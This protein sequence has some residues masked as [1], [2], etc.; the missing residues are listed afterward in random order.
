MQGRSGSAYL[1]V[2]PKCALIVW[3][4]KQNKTIQLIAGLT[5]KEVQRLEGQL[6]DTNRQRLSILL[7]KMKKAL[8]KNAPLPDEELY[9]AVF[10]EPY[11]KENNFKLRN[12]L[13]LLNICIT[14]FLV[15]ERLK[16]V[17]KDKST[18]YTWEYLQELNDRGLTDLFE[19]ESN[20]T[21]QQYTQTQDLA[22]L[23]KVLTQRLNHEL[24]NT[25]VTEEHY[26][27]HLT[28]IAQLRHVLE[29]QQLI[30]N[31]RL[32]YQWSFCRRVLYGLGQKEH[33]LPAPFPISN[34]EEPLP[35]LALFY[36][37]RANTYLCMG[38]EKIDLLLR[39]LNLC[40]TISYPDFNANQERFTLLAT[41]ALEYY[42]VRNFEQA[43]LYNQ[44]AYSQLHNVDAVQAAKFLHN[45]CSL[46]MR[47]ELFA[48]SLEIIQQH[49]PLI[50][51]T[52]VEPRMRILHAVSL[53][54]TGQPE[55]ALGI[56]PETIGSY[57]QFDRNYI[58]LLEA[59][60]LFDMDN[61]ETALY[62]VNA[63][64]KNL[65]TNKHFDGAPKEF[66]LLFKR[67]IMLEQGLKDDGYAPKIAILYQQ[68][69]EFMQKDNVLFGGDNF[70]VMWLMRKIGPTT[71]KV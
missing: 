45:Y 52:V 41:I 64:I 30:K 2:L 28:Q 67:Y 12:E 1:F 15:E 49:W 71:A 65:G 19:K 10:N 63:A 14:D 38:E 33:P 42:L 69:C 54:F 31:N 48:K 25:A 60:A 34:G 36:A 40:D 11:T 27:N 55:G 7:G 13:R 44:K 66:A 59:I 62:R 32:N 20:K 51:P 24:A 68:L 21:I 23:E 37:L 53:V 58:R 47:M 8:S 3:R 9:Q 18:A 39:L 35:S 6:A 29:G 22:N 46:L 57:A 43:L 16:Q 70:L 26:E 5:E 56:L 61:S 4:M 50:K 17:V